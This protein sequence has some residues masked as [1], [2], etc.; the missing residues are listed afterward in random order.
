MAR[1][2][3]NFKF[4]QPLFHEFDNVVV[5]TMDYGNILYITFNNGKEGKERKRGRIRLYKLFR[6]TNKSILKTLMP[7]IERAKALFYG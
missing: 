1:E 3:L 7:E 4:I 5:K 6:A 2:I